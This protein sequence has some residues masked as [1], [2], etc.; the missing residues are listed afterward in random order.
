ML[1]IS[2]WN[3]IVDIAGSNTQLHVFFQFRYRTTD[4]ITTDKMA[5]SF[6]QPGKKPSN[7]VM[8]GKKR[9]SIWCVKNIGN[10]SQ[11]AGYPSQ[12]T[13]F[14]RMKMNCVNK[15]FM[16]QLTQYAVKFC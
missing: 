14:R 13:T 12:E 5:G 16:F 2:Y 1:V 15:A 9:G 3:T 10:A 8:S 6:N 11:P 7:P 4:Y